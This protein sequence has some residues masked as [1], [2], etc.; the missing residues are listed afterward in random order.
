MK[1]NIINFVISLI[2]FF[3]FSFFEKNKKRFLKL[4][5]K[6]NEIPKGMDLNY[7]NLVAF[8]S[9]TSEVE[10]IKSIDISIDQYLK[11]EGMRLNNPKEWL[12]DKIYNFVCEFEYGSG[13]SMSH[14]KRQMKE[15]LGENPDLESCEKFFADYCK[16]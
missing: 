16:V 1:N 15:V 9:A 13:V 11:K 12:E 8:A 3:E 4:E 14:Y 2:S 6:F 10:A 7:S 5:K